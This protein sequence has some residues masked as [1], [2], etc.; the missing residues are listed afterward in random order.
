MINLLE[1]LRELRETL[2]STRLVKDVAEGAGER[3]QGEVWE[4]WEGPVEASELLSLR[5]GHGAGAGRGE[6]EMREGGGAALA[7]RG[8]LEL[9]AARA[10]CWGFCGGVPT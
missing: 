10:L 1:Q 4:A 5:H 7:A 9:E 6:G 8:L 3:P 2:T